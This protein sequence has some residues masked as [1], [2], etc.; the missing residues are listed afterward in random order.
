MK[1][2]II[3]FALLL[4]MSLLFAQD[5]ILLVGFVYDKEANNAPM[6]MAAIQIKNT[7]LGGMTDDNGYFEIPVPK[8]NLKDSLRVSFVGYLT[9]AVSVR[10]YKNGDTIRVSLATSTETKQEVVVVAMNAKGVLL[11]AI[12]NMKTNLLRDSLLSTGFYRQY[13]KEN[14]VYVRL[15]EA[16]VTVAFNCKNIYEY[17]FHESVRTNKVRRSKNYETNGDVHGDHLVDLLKENPYSYNRS[18]FLDPKKID[19]YSP[20][21]ESED[22][23]QY[24]IKLQYKESSSAKLENARVWVAKETYAITR[25]EIEKFPN[26]YYVKSR[27]ANDS[28]WKLVNEKNVIETEKIDGKYMVSS[29]TRSYNH[30]VLNKMTGNVDFIVE[31]AFEMHF[32]DF[33]TEQVGAALQKNFGAMTELYESKYKYDPAYWKKYEP[34]EE[35]EIPAQVFSDLEHN[36]KLEVQFI[37]AGK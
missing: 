2:P 11:K 24:V 12:T 7:Q 10:D 36:T 16:D 26:P 14:G 29:I 19:F 35:H 20:K 31:E 30:H 18:N 34:L 28:R 3:I 15:I 1:K 22:T 13:H 17:S 23:A 8:V 9:Q 21:F 32:Y 27:Y 5:N 37:E 6:S 4:S 33:E 25:V